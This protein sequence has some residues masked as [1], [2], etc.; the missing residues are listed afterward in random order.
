MKNKSQAIGMNYEN[1]DATVLDFHGMH[2]GSL[3]TIY[4]TLT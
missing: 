1:E 3:L 4:L 2:I